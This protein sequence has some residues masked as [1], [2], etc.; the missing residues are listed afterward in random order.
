MGPA[1]YRF[2]SEEQ[3]ALA[4]TLTELLAAAGSRSADAEAPLDR[5]S[6]RPEAVA[7]IVPGD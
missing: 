5:G 2:A 1:G 4:L 3:R 6:P 7:R